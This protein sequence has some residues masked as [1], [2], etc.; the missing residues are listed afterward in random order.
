MAPFQG[1]TFHSQP[2]FDQFQGGAFDE[3]AFIR[4]GQQI[5]A[6]GVTT[7][8]IPVIEQTASP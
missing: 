6:I 8:R 7:D 4:F 3:S 1:S 5:A 2:S